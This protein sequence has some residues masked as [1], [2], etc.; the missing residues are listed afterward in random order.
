M[1]YPLVSGAG[2]NADLVPDLDVLGLLTTTNNIIAPF[3]V[4]VPQPI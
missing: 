3:D 2:G 1:M 4:C